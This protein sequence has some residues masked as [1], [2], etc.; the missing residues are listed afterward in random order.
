MEGHMAVV[1]E[2]PL[3]F[4]SSLA[5][6]NIIKTENSTNRRFLSAQPPPST[7]VSWSSTGGEKST[8]VELL[9]LLQKLQTIFN[10]GRINARK[11]LVV[12]ILG[13]CAEYPRF[14]SFG[15]GG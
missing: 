10:I 6:V 12:N 11:K 9:L 5:V 13:H 4:V 1:Y 2:C 3:V 15:R 14:S 7:A 8:S